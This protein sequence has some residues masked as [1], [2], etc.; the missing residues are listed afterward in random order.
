MNELDCSQVEGL[1]VDYSDGEL[2]A[3]LTTR[4]EA[5]V[6]RCT[7]CQS[8][9]ARLDTSLS[10]ASEVWQQSARSIGD[11]H[12]TPGQ[13]DR[14]NAR[15]AVLALA[16][17]AA[18]LLIGLFAWQSATQ[19]DTPLADKPE[20]QQETPEPI[21]ADTNNEDTSHTE[22]ETSEQDLLAVI[23]RM[24]RRARLQVSLELLEQTPSLHSYA[25]EAK[26]Y[27]A[28][29]YGDLDGAEASGT[30]DPSGTQEERL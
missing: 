4:V 14:R 10:L 27:L 3:E 30:N 13:R 22:V 19:K 1:L 29:A 15:R 6:E 21:L 2:E 12:V 8:R 18:V 28:S 24:E 20:S 26:Q 11:V 25:E 16:S 23:D 9:L 7:E 5:H 17:L